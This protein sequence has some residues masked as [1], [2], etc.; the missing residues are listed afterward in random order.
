MLLK[1]KLD[2]SALL[3]FLQCFRA[4]VY[5]CDLGVA[6]QTGHYSRVADLV[7]LQPLPHI[8]NELLNTPQSTCPSATMS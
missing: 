4:W 1:I 3:Q 2:V 8:S 5:V 7:H 6:G